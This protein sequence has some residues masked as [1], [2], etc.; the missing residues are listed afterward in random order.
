MN[1]KYGEFEIS[2]NDCNKRKFAFT[3]KLRAY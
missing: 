2:G 3:K 1:K